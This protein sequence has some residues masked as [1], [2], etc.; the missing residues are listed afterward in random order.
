M[1]AVLILRADTGSKN[2]HPPKLTNVDLK[3]VLET[4]KSFKKL[5]KTHIP[6]KTIEILN[7]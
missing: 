6:R 1:N 4:V 2:D 7:L 5:N 3:K